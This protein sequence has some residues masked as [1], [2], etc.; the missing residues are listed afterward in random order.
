[1]ISERFEIRDDVQRE[2]C[3]EMLYPDQTG[4]L[5]A[6]MHLIRK[7]VLRIHCRCENTA[8][9]Q[10]SRKG[11]VRAFRSFRAE[12]WVSGLYFTELRHVFG[13]RINM[14]LRPPVSRYEG[15][16]HR[17]NRPVLTGIAVYN[18]PVSFE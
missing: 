18:K 11:V 3:Q 16:Q 7:T 14:G 2:V 4:G 6:R 10:V 9:R 5:S 12:N 17:V 8:A 1:M 13:I 15:N